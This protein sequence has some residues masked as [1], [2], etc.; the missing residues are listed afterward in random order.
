MVKLSMQLRHENGQIVHATFVDVVLCCSRLA[1]FVQQCCA[2][3]CALV[4]FSTRSMSQPRSQGLF[5][6]L[7]AKLLSTLN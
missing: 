5:P 3:A 7:G 4:R 2:R 1:R 6:G